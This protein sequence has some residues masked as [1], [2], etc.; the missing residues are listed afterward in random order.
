MKVLAMPLKQMPVEK[1]NEML[2]MLH[3]L[4]VFFASTQLLMKKRYGAQLEKFTNYI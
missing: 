1:L 4:H 2:L 3:L